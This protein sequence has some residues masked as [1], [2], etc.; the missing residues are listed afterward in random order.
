LEK[1]KPDLACFTH[2]AGSAVYAADG[3]TS[4]ATPVAA[5]DVAAIRRLFPS[6]VLPPAQLRDML[7]NTAQHKGAAGHNFDYGYGVINDKALLLAFDKWAQDHG[8]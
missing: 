6:H 7:R 2:F 4:A 5:G 8:M 1:K 3:G